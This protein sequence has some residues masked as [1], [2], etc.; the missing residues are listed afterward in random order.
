[1]NTHGAEMR[2][3]TKLDDGEGQVR[4]A[5]CSESCQARKNRT[6]TISMESI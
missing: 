3:M 5:T 4:A 1:M 6:K 2:R